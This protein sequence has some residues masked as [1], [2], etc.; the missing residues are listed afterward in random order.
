MRTILAL[1]AATLAAALLTGCAP[2]SEPQ[3]AA[4]DGSY[5]TLADLR[6]AYEGAGGECEE[7][8][9]HEVDGA[10]EAG[11]C[12]GDTTM[13]IFPDEASRDA[14]VENV[15]SGTADIGGAV[16][17]VGP[18]WILNDQDAEALQ[19]DLGGELVDSRP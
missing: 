5:A 14:I 8:F 11:D 10:L 1:T 2:G 19:A 13:Q 16:L 18:N 9:E 3:P 4:A 15:L 12:D 6:A 17:L 7:W